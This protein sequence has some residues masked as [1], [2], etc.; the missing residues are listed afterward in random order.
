MEKYF[1]KK[2][3]T[4]QQNDEEVK[5]PVSRKRKAEGDPP[6]TQGNPKKLKT[7]DTFE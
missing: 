7:G 3:A 6:E 1:P 2:G 5:A 4:K